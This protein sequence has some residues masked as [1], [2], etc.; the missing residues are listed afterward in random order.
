MVPSQPPDS[1]ITCG[2]AFPCFNAWVYGADVV[3]PIIDFGQ[4]SAWRPNPRA[5]WG[6]WGENLRWLFI[7][8]GWVL[9]SLFVA[10][11]TALVR[12]E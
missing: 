9:A 10:A 1:G 3:L 8:V 11:F 12:R 7:V 5:S 4:D 2:E 6:T